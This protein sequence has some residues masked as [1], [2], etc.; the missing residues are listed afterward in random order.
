M[1]AL[2]K[3]KLQEDFKAVHPFYERLRDG[4]QFILNKQLLLWW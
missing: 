2:D 1:V 4:V 3:A